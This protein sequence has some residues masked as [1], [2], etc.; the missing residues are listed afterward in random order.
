[1]NSFGFEFSERIGIERDLYSSKRL[2]QTVH[3]QKAKLLSPK[4]IQVASTEYGKVIIQQW[5]VCGLPNDNLSVGN[6]IIIATARSLVQGG[7]GPRLGTASSRVAQAL[8]LDD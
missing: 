2:P 4:Q 3:I 5:A 6:G 8:A 7:N 1:M